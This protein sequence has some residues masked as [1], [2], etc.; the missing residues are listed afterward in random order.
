[1]ELARQGAAVAVNYR[2]RESAAS[3]VTDEITQAGGRAI[4]VQ[5]DV[6]EY[7]QVDR[8]VETVLATL[9][10][11]HVLVNCAGTTYDAL[12]YDMEPERWLDVMRVNFGGVFNCTR[13]A[14]EHLMRQR[15]GSIVNISSPLADR[16]WSG[17][18]AYAA[19]KSAVNAFTRSCA[20]EFGR[21]GIR[22]NGVAPGLVDTD[23]VAAV[24]GT[25]ERRAMAANIPL[26]SLATPADI[27]RVVTFL[28]GS[29]S[30]YMTGGL[31][32]VDGGGSVV[33]GSGTVGTRSGP[34]RALTTQGRGHD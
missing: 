8:M 31:V 23:L 28:A 14:A 34:P 12:I 15:E 33:M 11:L 32:T 13:A 20:V 26:R 9:G 17:T 3:A 7:G 25:A 30:A 6:S 22:V 18:A 16:V 5:A 4:A 2:S 24:A 27:A 19:S 1:L 10:G 21:F 29:G